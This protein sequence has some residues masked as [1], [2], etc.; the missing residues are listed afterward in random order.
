MLIHAMPE[1]V[2]ELNHRQPLFGNSIRA[3][4][5]KPGLPAGIPGYSFPRTA[6]L[7]RKSAPQTIKKTA[8]RTR[9]AAKRD[10]APSAQI[11]KMG[12]TSREDMESIFKGVSWK[13]K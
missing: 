5:G 6:F 1:C 8:P 7:I 9:A 11:K 4:E 12:K 13:T 10:A 3:D 2:P